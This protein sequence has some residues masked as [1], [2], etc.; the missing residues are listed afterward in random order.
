MFISCFRILYPKLS[1]RLAGP[2]HERKTASI[3]TLFC[4]CSQAPGHAAMRSRRCPGTGTASWEHWEMCLLDTTT[5]VDVR[6]QIPRVLRIPSQRSIDVLFQAYDESDLTV[7]TAS[8][9]RLNASSQIR[10]PS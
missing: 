5:P 6:R 3:L 10:L 9:K 2:L 4:D 7:R 1:P 8:S